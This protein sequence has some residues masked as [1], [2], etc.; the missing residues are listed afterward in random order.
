MFNLIHLAT[1]LKVDV[2]VLTPRPFDRASFDRRVSVVFD[3]TRGRAFKV[4]TAEDAVL[5]KLEWCR[6]GGEVSDRQWND[7][8]GVLKVQS[9]ALDLV[10]M[11][12][13]A[14]VLDVEA[15]LDRALA[16]A[17]VLSR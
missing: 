16:E 7:L 12:R 4:D 10:Y 6:A 13:W 5:H 14:A 3:P 17:S 8:V 15:L 9:A 11:R 2:Y 1:M